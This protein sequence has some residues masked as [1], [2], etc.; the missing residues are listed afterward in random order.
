[1]STRILLV[2]ILLAQTRVDV[3]TQAQNVI[4]TLPGSGIVTWRTPF[5]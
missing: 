2:A 1:M 4:G 5:M 3:S